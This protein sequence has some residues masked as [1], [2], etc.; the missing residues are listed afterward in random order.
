VE[1]LVN[2]SFDHALV[3]S[4]NS[5]DLLA[6]VKSR[7]H[8]SPDSGVHSRGIAAARENPDPDNL[9][10]HFRVTSILLKEKSAHDEGKIALPALSPD[11]RSPLSP[12][13]VERQGPLRRQQSRSLVKLRKKGVHV[14]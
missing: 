7:A 10:G 4:P 14:L 1:H 9:T 12:D 11:E 8:D 13:G 3:A 2:L 5:E 6:F